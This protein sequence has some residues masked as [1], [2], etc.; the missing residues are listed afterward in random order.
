MTY[1]RKIHLCAFSWIF[2]NN[3]PSLNDLT[4]INPPE[5]ISLHESTLDHFNIGLLEEVYGNLLLNNKINSTKDGAKTIIKYEKKNHKHV[6]KW[7]GGTDLRIT[8]EVG[9]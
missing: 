1:L 9:Q 3:R 2:F 7:E 4:L 8:V 5:Q 6:K